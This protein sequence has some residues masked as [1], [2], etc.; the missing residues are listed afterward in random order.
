MGWRRS[1]PTLAPNPESTKDVPV[2]RSFCLLQLAILALSAP[3]LADVLGSAPG[4]SA[5]D[6][7]TLVASKNLLTGFPAKAGRERVNVVVE[8]PTGSTQKWEVDKQ[9][10][11]LRWEFKK[12]KPRVVKYLGYPG[13]Y[14][15]IPRTLL[16]EEL[17]GDGD[18]LDVLI[19]G[20]ALPRGSVVEARVVAVLRL[21]DGGE[22]DD[23]LIA[24]PAE[25]AFSQVRDLSSL[26]SSF[27]N[28][29]EIIELWFTSYKG[30]G[31]MES[32]GWADAPDAMR[33]LDAAAAAFEVR[34]GSKAPADSK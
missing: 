14:G 4:L 33:I 25:G 17:G 19:L 22:Q 10:G 5:P 29:S 34:G 13:N 26:R 24:V 31:E 15:M 1:S 8:I 32:R 28:T 11:S 3:T 2:K 27:A 6:P 18:P 7:Y 23:K 30:P 21:L 20:P 16:P 12:G 9:D